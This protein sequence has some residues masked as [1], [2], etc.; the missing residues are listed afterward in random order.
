MI[1]IMK[2]SDLAQCGTIYAKAFPM[3]HWGI[4][5]TTEMPQNIFRIFLNREDLWDLYM[6]KKRSTRVYIRAS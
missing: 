5:W 2:A 6:R 1:R 3:E 4:D